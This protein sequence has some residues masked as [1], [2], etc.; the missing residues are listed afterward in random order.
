MSPV[1]FVILFFFRFDAHHRTF[2]LKQCYEKKTEGMKKEKKKNE[3]AMM[4]K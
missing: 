1:F 2:S 3:T 4:S